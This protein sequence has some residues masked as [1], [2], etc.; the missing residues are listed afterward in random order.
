M[1]NK[2]L[3]S[4]IAVSLLV[5]FT[6]IKSFAAENYRINGFLSV[7]GG[8]TLGKGDTR[9]VDWPSNGAYNDELDYSPDTVLGIQ[10]QFVINEKTTA[11]G[12]LV[13]RGG[14]DLNTEVEWAYVSFAVT[15]DLT[16]HAGRKRAPFYL[17]S[18]F[19]DVGYTYHWIRP[20][21]EIYGDPFTS[22]NGI[23]ADYL[24]S[25]GD[26]DM[27]VGLYSGS[28]TYED[29]T[30][31]I[32]S[33]ELVFDV[34]EIIGGFLTVSN[35]TYLLRTNY[36][37]GKVSLSFGE[38]FIADFDGDTSI[39]LFLPKGT[40]IKEDSRV[41]FWGF[42]AKANYESFFGIAEYTK[43]LLLPRGDFTNYYLSIGARI[44]KLTPHLTYSNRL[45]DDVETKA[46]KS[47]TS[48]VTLGI[49]WDVALDVAL[50]IEYQEVTE[51]EVVGYSGNLDK[52]N[53]A[54]DVKL[55]S[56]GVD[57]IF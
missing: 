38:N 55:I 52:D 39:D 25:L 8:K 9:R 27:V 34:D 33:I 42:A 48:A 16:I 7:V 21:M 14:D 40:V 46:E 10:L 51:D 2:K 5:V 28:E 20:P 12:Q 36:F 4:K 54:S 1:I 57:L 18:D 44:G 32:D 47:E 23:S 41:E 19:L 31:D 50:K 24:I 17:Y 3:V 45:A 53:V 30:D 43:T 37:R 29:D 6:P 26:W 13:S 11:T 56:F 49:R 15:N 35:H 22:Y